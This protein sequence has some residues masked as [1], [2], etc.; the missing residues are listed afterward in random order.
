MQLPLPFQE[1]GARD[2]L[3]HITAYLHEWLARDYKALGYQ[4]V[5]VPVQ[6]AQ[7]RLEFVLAQ[8]SEQG[9]M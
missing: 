6:P 1:Y 2:G 9:R 7:G 5:R 4:V 3:S 8:L